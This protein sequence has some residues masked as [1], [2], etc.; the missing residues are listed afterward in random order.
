ME[1]LS[2]VKLHN[3]E[4]ELLASCVRVHFSQ[5][6]IN[7]EKIRALLQR[8][9]DWTYFLAITSYNRVIPLVWKSLCTFASHK[10]PAAVTSTFKNA[11]FQI[12]KSNLL[13]LHKLRTLL[14]LFEEN[15]IAVIPF[16]GPTLGAFY[17]NISLREFSDLDIIIRKEDIF[18]VRELLI[19]NDYLP[20]CNPN[21]LSLEEIIERWH[22][23]QFVSKDGTVEIDVHW[24]LA[25]NDEN[26]N[27]PMDK[28]WEQ[29][30]R[31]S[32]LNR[33]VL[34]LSPK[35]FILSTCLHHGM[36]SGWNELRMIADFAFIV[37][38]Y[39]Q[40]NWDEIILSAKSMGG[41]KTLL[42]GI[43]LAHKLFG[44][45][46]PPQ[47]K[48]EIVNNNSVKKV[49][50]QILKQ[51]FTINNQDRKSLYMQRIIRVNIRDNFYIKLTLIL[52]PLMNKLRPSSLDRNFIP[53]S[54]PSFLY[55]LYY[56]IRPFRLANKYAKNYLLRR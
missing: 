10:V 48:S 37:N 9:I 53:I 26:I 11:F 55:F 24:C 1:F 39:K 20:C 46:I 6:G 44:L 27:F 47:I 21:S 49:A 35:D 3:E 41:Y 54:L 8:D 7:E 2:N 32:F 45:D 15:N 22:S 40:L 56:I 50:S 34:M 5:K 29:S 28:L 23:Y 52:T 43:S 16:K 18:K 25:D 36:R 42:V 51:L 17:S 14:K 13:I 12:G 30:S 31:Q 33:Q 19:S 4:T 38:S